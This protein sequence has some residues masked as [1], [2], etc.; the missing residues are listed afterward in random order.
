M[1]QRSS[2]KGVFT[3]P[4]CLTTYEILSCGKQNLPI[5]LASPHSG[6]DYPSE[7]IEQTDLSQTLLRQSEDCY[8]DQIMTPA[9]QLGAPLIRALFPRVFVDVNREAFELDPDMFDGP[10]PGYVNVASHRAAAGIGT[11]ARTVPGGEEIY[12][13]KLSFAAIRKRI[14]DYYYPYHAA[15]RQMIDQTRAEFGHCLLLDCHSMPSASCIAEAGFG[16]PIDFVLGDCHR[17]S[18]DNRIVNAAERFLSHRGFR[19]TRNRPYA[20]GYTTRHYGQPRHHINALQIEINRALYLNERDYTA[21][22][23][24]AAIADVMADLVSHLAQAVPLQMAA[25]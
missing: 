5:V 12:R 23:D 13:D 17:T 1:G 19:V 11:I 16:Q 2:S 22:P 21:L 7:F 10:L 3:P 24:M 14:I 18:C 4:S 6:T 20:G 8:I 9:M 25:E 15:L